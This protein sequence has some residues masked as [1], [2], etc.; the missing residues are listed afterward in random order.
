MSM[1][2]RFQ[3]RV[4][5]MSALPSKRGVE[6]CAMGKQGPEIRNFHGCGSREFW[7]A[8][9]SLCFDVRRRVCKHGSISSKLCTYHARAEVAGIMVDTVTRYG[10]SMLQDQSVGETSTLIG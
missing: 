1:E 5:E 8:I 6:K 7:L 9:S 2:T 10:H 3:R 4:I